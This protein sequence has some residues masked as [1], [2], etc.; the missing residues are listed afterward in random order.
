M[1]M[2]RRGQTCL[3]AVSMVLLFLFMTVL[4]SSSSSHPSSPDVKTDYQLLGMPL[5]KL[6]LSW[7]RNPELLTGQVFAV[8]VNPHTGV[9][10]VAQRGKQRFAS[11]K[12]DRNT[13]CCTKTKRFLYR[14][15]AL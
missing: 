8:A 3:I 15:N 7:P 1:W 9:L 12:T 4:Y 11:P 5:Y 14:G 6:D 2:N 13:I 10:Y